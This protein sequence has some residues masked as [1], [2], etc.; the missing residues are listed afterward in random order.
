MGNTLQ[1]QRAPEMAPGA[2]PTQGPLGMAQNMLVAKGVNSGVN[3]ATDPKSWQSLGNTLNPGSVDLAANANASGVDPMQHMLDANSGFNTY[4][5]TAPAVETAA[6]ET[7]MAGSAPLSAA[8]STGATAG[9]EAAAT[10]AAAEAA[11]AA[12]AAGTTAATGAATAG[13]A[14]AAPLA[15]MGPVGMGVAGLLLAK[16]FGYI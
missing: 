13:A 4:A 6:V 12:T 14:S 2:A 11:A 7:T 5:G 9:A 3:T 10:T 15:A 1:S 8:A 16:K